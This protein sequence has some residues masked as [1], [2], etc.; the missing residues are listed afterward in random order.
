[1]L[2][3]L[4]FGI[5]SS[6]PYFPKDALQEWTHTI[7]IICKDCLNS[8]NEQHTDDDTLLLIPA[9]YGTDINNL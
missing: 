2:H 4:Q 5:V 9:L 6:I 7:N 8:V 3:T 1:M